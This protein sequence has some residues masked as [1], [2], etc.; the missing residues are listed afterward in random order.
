MSIFEIPLKY[1]PGEFPFHEIDAGAD[2][3]REVL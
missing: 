3:H 2:L 1:K